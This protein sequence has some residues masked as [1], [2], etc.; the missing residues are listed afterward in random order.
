MGLLTMIDSYFV[1]SAYFTT[2]LKGASSQIVFGF[3]VGR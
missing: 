1:S 2:L 3:E